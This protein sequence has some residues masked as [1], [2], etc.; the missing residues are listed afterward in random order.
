MAT[1]TVHAQISSCT[2]DERYRSYKTL[3]TNIAE[4][5][6]PKDVEKLAFHQDADQL[7]QELGGNIQALD[8]LKLL[9]KRGVIGPTPTKIEAL[10]EILSDIQRHDLNNKLVEPFEKKFMTCKFSVDY[11]ELLLCYYICCHVL[12]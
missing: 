2:D 6:G 10:K 1:V 9:E 11:K 4:S 5:I 8:L 12:N 3:V 7:R